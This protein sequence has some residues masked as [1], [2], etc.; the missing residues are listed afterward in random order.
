MRSD[1]ELGLV[2]N[3]LKYI[4]TVKQRRKERTSAAGRR[5]REV[6]NKRGEYLKA[7]RVLARGGERPEEK[8]KGNQKGEGNRETD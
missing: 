3:R 2:I 7:N 4:E 6:N 5:R 1:K 8:R